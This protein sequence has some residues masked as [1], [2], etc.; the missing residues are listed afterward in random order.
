MQE[1]VE[2][3]G[4]AKRGEGQTLRRSDVGRAV[5]RSEFVG[6]GAQSGPGRG[7]ATAPAHRQVQA[8]DLSSSITA[9]DC[10]H[11]AHGLLSDS[12]ARQR[13]A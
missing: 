6:R 11:C 1:D 3:H 9:S 8:R 2:G 12:E 7:R 5:E 13:P 4:K 10:A